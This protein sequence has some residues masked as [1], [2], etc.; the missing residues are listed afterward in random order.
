[1]IFAGPDTLLGKEMKIIRE[2][3]LEGDQLKLVELALA[4]FRA[5]GLDSL[6]YRLSF[7]R[8][9]NGYVAIFEDPNVALG[10]RGSSPN[11][12][13]FEVELN[14]NLEVIRSNFMR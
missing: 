13:S 8:T 7:Y 1:M 12:P 9:E 11:M 4:E 2:I 6:D 10:Q 3:A 5:N 14:D